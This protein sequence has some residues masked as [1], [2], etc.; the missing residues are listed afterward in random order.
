M[1][2]VAIVV[3]LLFLVGGVVGLTYHLY[4]YFNGSY[5]GDA[6]LE[7]GSTLYLTNADPTGKLPPIDKK[8]EA[9]QVAKF[10]HERVTYGSLYAGVPIVTGC[11]LILVAWRW[12]SGLVAGASRAVTDSTGPG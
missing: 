8:K 1:R 9:A 7:F 3:G 12:K 10:V 4:F 6:R 2:K 11:I 5:E